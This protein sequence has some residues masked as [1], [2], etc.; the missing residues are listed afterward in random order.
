MPDHKLVRHF[1]LLEDLTNLSEVFGA[2]MSSLPFLW[3]VNAL[4]K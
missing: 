3:E 1:V 4:L 2:G